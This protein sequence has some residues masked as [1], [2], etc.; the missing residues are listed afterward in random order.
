MGWAGFIPTRVGRNSISY[1]AILA[2]KFS[3][4]KIR[5]FLN[6]VSNDL[7]HFQD[8][9]LAFDLGIEQKLFFIFFFQLGIIS[10]GIH[11]CHVVLTI[12]CCK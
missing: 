7:F 4:I 1:F 6:S 10:D 11:V 2:P 8:L 3:I 9:L 12:F 5:Y